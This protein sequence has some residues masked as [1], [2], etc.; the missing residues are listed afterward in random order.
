MQIQNQF[1]QKSSEIIL[2]HGLISFT[3]QILAKISL[4]F[5]DYICISTEYNN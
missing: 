2:K 4:S 5:D 3:S 1:L